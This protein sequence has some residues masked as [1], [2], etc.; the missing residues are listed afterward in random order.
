MT[1]LLWP[2]SWRV[3]RN[4]YLWYD[5]RIAESVDRLRWMLG[6]RF[7]L[8][9]MRNGLWRLRVG[10]FH[11]SW[12]HHVPVLKPTPPMERADAYELG[13]RCATVHPPRL[14][15]VAGGAPVLAGREFGLNPC[16][17]WSPEYEEWDRGYLET[18]QAAAE[19]PPCA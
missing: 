7:K 9:H 14:I 6:W 13:R 15:P 1:V 12:P 19:E 8:K 5:R 3:E 10:P 18:A 4:L 17:L 11:A 2:R 16:R